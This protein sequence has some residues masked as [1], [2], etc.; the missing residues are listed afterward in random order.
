V[1]HSSK[2]SIKKQSMHQFF[3]YDTDNLSFDHGKSKQIVSDQNQNLVNI[4]ENYTGQ[5]DE[6][7][8]KSQQF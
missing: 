3:C 6:V 8:K 5:E 4:I 1:Q 7:E 2:Q